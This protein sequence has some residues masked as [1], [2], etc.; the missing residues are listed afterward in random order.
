MKKFSNKFIKKLPED[1]WKPSP[2]EFPIILKTYKKCQ[3]G[4]KEI[5]EKFL[6]HILRE[7]SQRSKPMISRSNSH[8]S[9]GKRMLE[10]FYEIVRRIC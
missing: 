1:F 8:R 6:S 3:R 5:V 4:H 2:R 7:L 10:F 9:F